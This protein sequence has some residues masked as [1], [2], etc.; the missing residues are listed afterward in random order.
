MG[1]TGVV[2]YLILID[3]NLKVTLRQPY[4]GIL[5]AFLWGIFLNKIMRLQRC[6]NGNE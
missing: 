5:F 4:P 2:L 6:T 1:L 3:N